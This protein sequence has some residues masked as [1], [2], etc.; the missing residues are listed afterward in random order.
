MRSSSS[1]VPD[2][3]EGV[4]AA[5]LEAVDDLLGDLLV[6]DDDDGLGVEALDEVVAHL[7]EVRAA[8]GAG[9]VDNGAGDLRPHRVDQPLPECHLGPRRRPDHLRGTRR[10]L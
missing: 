7:D 4:D 10:V 1:A 8:L 3:A 2:G 6:G 9:V 5:G